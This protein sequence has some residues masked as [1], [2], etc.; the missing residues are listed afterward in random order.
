MAL[1]I[2]HSHITDTIKGYKL[3]LNALLGNISHKI[4]RTCL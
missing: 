4:R 1:T 3:F 2:E